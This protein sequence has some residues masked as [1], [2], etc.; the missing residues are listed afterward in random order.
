MQVRI[1]EDRDG[2][3]RGFAFVE[4]GTLE[5]A[6][7]ALRCDGKDLG[8]R[9]MRV[10]VTTRGSQTRA[11]LFLF[12]HCLPDLCSVRFCIRVLPRR[13]PR[14]VVVSCNRRRK[15]RQASLSVLAALTPVLLALATSSATVQLL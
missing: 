15:H 14:C 6:Q 2:R 3:R 13:R 8:G 9:A 12:F 7:A 10:D 1:A 5:E 4:F 11:P